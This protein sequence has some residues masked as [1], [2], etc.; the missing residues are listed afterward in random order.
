M[1]AECSFTVDTTETSDPDWEGG[2]VQ[3]NRFA[4][5]FTGELAGTSVVEATMFGLAD[6]SAAAYVGIERFE[7]T[8]GGAKGSF[9]LTHRA[10]IVDGKQVAELVILPGTGTDDLKGITGTADLLPDHHLTLHYELP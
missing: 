4:K 10:T 7:G 8:V 9:V 1:R 3:R 2:A 6:G 5:V